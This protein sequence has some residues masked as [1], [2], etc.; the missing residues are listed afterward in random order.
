MMVLVLTITSIGVHI[1]EGMPDGDQDMFSNKAAGE[2]DIDD[3]MN[4]DMDED[5]ACMKH[6]LPVGCIPKFIN[7]AKGQRVFVSSTTW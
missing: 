1:T 5:D 3:D 6:G 2:E 4:E 7:V